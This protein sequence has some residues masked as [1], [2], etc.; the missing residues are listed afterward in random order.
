VLDAQVEAGDEGCLQWSV[1]GW[2]LFNI[3]V[4]DIDDGL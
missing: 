4:N 2:V 1:L 3:F